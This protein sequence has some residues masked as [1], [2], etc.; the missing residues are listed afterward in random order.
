MCQNLNHAVAIFKVQDSV[1]TQLLQMLPN[2]P[3]SRLVQPKT[4]AYLL[5]LSFR[6]LNETLKMI[7]EQVTSAYL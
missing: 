4:L 3:G 6:S 5:S 7:I 2:A 1:L